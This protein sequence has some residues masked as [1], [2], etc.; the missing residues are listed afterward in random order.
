MPAII[1]LGD[2]NEL[3]P[4][5]SFP[6]Y[7]NFS[8]DEFNPVQSR[9][10]EIYN[11]DCNAIIA[12][13]TSSGKTAIAEMFLSNEVRERGGKGLYL[14]PLKALAQEKIDDWSSDDHHFKDL[15]ISICTGDYRITED[16][17]KELAAAN[18]ILMTS[19]MLSHRC[20]N[21]KS[22]GNSFLSEVGTLVVDEFHLIGVDGRG[23]HL[24]AALMKFT[25]VNP[26]IRLV[27]LSATMPNVDQI[28]EWVSY[29]LTKKETYLIESSY[30]PCPLTIHYEKCYDGDKKYEDR[31]LQKVAHALQIVEDYPDD[32]FLVFSHTKRTGRHM[33]TALERAGINCGYHN[34]DLTKAK[35]L[36]LERDFKE[37][38]DLRVLVATSTVAW[39]LNLPARRVVILGVHRGLSQV[40]NYDIQQMSGRAG[41]PKYDP[42]GDVY[43]LIPES[44][45]DHY[46]K[47]LN[48]KQNIE[49]QMLDTLGGHHKIMAFHVVSEIHHGSIRNKDDFRDWYARSLAAFQSMQLDDDVID[50]LVDL[51]LKKGIIREHEGE[52]KVNAVGKISSMFYFDPF[53]VADLRRNFSSIFENN[54]QDNDYAISMALASVESCKLGIV[55]KNEEEEMVSFSARIRKMFGNIKK[56]VIKA[57]YAY[58]LLLKGLPSQTFNP[59]MRGLQ[60]DFPRLATVLKSIDSMSAKWDQKEWLGNL[61]T[62]VVYGVDDY[63]VGLC[64]LPHIGKVRAN[65]L[66]NSNIRSYKD[67]VNKSSLVGKILRLEDNKTK[68]VISKAKSLYK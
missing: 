62:R 3:I 66:W 22:E 13:S 16:R 44:Q 67:I 48:R 1:K 53:D 46:V 40:E 8:F 63:L 56:P 51:L 23:D 57:A 60:M 49:S 39:G 19:E 59:Y 31:E 50:Q 54:R 25:Q 15:K 7:A 27:F 26:N 41:R 6:D 38:P 45:A 10:Y 28:G 2:Q 65:K 68:E 34:A 52:Y 20:R 21:H 47:K 14:S 5:S 9:A 61:Q 42:S 64:N 35:R 37:D 29:E 17:K 36:R 43:V 18:L 4:A 24:E 12:S 33:K 30:R 32:K 11:R 55:S 58:H